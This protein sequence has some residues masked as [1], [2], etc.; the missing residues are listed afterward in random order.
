MQLPE[1]NW[2]GVLVP[3]WVAWVWM[4]L[5]LVVVAGFGFGLLKLRS[6][7]REIAREKDEIEGEEHRMFEFLHLLGGMI[8]EHT[9]DR[10]LYKVIVEGLEEVLDGEGAALYLNS[11]DGGHLVPAYLSEGCPPLMSVPE[12]VWLDGKADRKALSSYLRLAKVPVGRGVLGWCLRRGESM[13]VRDVGTHES[14]EGLEYGGGIEAMLAPVRHGGKD[15]GVFLVVRQPGD[16]RF[17][18][19]D[20]AVFRSLAEQSSFALLNSMVHREAGEKRRMVRELRVA[21]DV[22]QVLLPGADPDLPGYRIYGT[23]VPARIISGDYYDYIPL[24][25]N[26]L[27]VAIA[28]VSGKGVSAGLMMATCR[29]ALRAAA[30][31]TSPAG[32]LAA[33]NRQ[34]FPDMREDM[35]ISMAYVVLEN[36]MGRM[37][38]ARAGHDAPLMFRKGSGEVEVM[39][40]TGLALGIDEGPVFE[41]VTGDFEAQFETGDCLLLYTDGVNEAENEAGEEFGKDRMRE[42]F[43]TAASRGADQVVS[44]LQRELGEFVGGNKQM[45]DITLIA[46]EKR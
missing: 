38:M 24:E 9:V 1:V 6:R 43:R 17:T 10:K 45:D 35:F 31:N 29:S 23:N 13:W 12:E 27:G 19:N 22:Q 11:H 32:A 28:D 18:R 39:K 42:V 5:V 14:M 37:T 36:G 25:N 40:P 41:R 3:D 34:L 2:L 20:F 7:L 46:I 21:R 4:G 26:Q 44:E 15:L 8:E 16:A 30:G 33:V